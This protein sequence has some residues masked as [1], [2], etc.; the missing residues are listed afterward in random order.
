MTEYKGKHTIEGEVDKFLVYVRGLIESGRVNP[1]NRLPSER[2]M[3]AESGVSRAKVRLG[4]ER[5]E[6]YGVLMT[7]PQSG[8]VLATH[9]REALTRQISDI[10]DCKAY[11]FKS[12]VHARTMLESEAVRLCAM[13]HTK[14]DLVK[15]RQSLQ[16]FIDYAETPLRDEKDFAFHSTIARCCHNPVIYSLQLMIDPDVLTFYRK[17]GACAMP[18]EG[19]IA[20]HSR[21][22][23]RIEERDPE[24]AVAEL[25]KHFETI[26]AFAEKH[27]A[28]VPMSRL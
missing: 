13:N 5:L 24:G 4:L 9:S 3:A 19:I 1:G 8:S 21:I 16:E 2:Q 15:L 28:I 6:L 11:D 22:L 12:L 7:L 23:E 25:L 18:P 20:E 27:H 10:L 17:L 14:E 26:T